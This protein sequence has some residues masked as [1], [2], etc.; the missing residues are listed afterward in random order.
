M[1]LVQQEH[2][3][4]TDNERLSTGALESKSKRDNNTLLQRKS[5]T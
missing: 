5:N 2:A 3:Q 1:K 4:T